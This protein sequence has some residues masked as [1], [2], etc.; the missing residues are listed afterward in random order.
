MLKLQFTD[1]RQSSFWIVDDDFTIGSELK[2]QMVIKD[3]HV[4]PQ[5]ARL[6][7][8][9]QRL[10]V[11][12]ID[13]NCIVFVN[14]QRVV[15]ETELMVG[16]LMILNTVELKLIDP[17]RNQRPL[18]G[19]LAGGLGAPAKAAGREE[20]TGFPIWQ[21][22]A[23][24]GPLNGK[25]LAID[26]S[27]IVGRDP[28]ADI[29]ISGGHISRRHAELLLRDG[30][31]WVKDLNSS[32]GTYVNNKKSDEQPIYFG[33]EIKFDAVIF[34]V[35]AGAHAPKGAEADE[36]P[37]DKTQFR[38]ALSIPPK[39]AVVEKPKPALTPQ[40]AAALVPSP[41]PAPAPSLT[42]TAPQP[43]VTVAKAAAKP[44]AAGISPLIV[45]VMLVVIIALV[46]VIMM[47]RGGG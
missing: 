6:I 30:Q 31:L 9:G 45:M 28:A 12:P 36:V 26:S 33:D 35:I 2:N 41:E 39:P 27:K 17:T 23:M 44:R 29:V 3:D 10:F 19:G 25:V 5:H 21:I 37:M 13:E 34:R 22:K 1:N 43:T 40:P 16:D 47:T 18:G 38:P 32:N 42:Q 20:P 46:A 11:A 14:G 8:R 7:K 24:T 4:R 15:T